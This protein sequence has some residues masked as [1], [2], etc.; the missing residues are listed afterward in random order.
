MDPG[1]LKR[2]VTLQTFTQTDDGAGGFI[3]GWQDITTVWAS[4]TPL[5]GRELYQAQQ[6]DAEVTH[7]VTIRY[8]ENVNSDMRILYNNR[9]LTIQSIINVDENNRF[10]ELICQERR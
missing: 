2:R 6:V 3:D 1:K 4:I 7:R 5:Q 8:R 9:E 10:L